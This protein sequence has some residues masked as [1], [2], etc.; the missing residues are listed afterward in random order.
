V[1]ESNFTKPY[2]C[3]IIFEHMLSSKITTAVGFFL[4]IALFFPYN[5]AYSANA[6]ELEGKVKEYQSKVNELQG[7]AKSLS[8]QIQVMD[9]QIKLTEYRIASTQTQMEVLSKDI[10]AASNKIN[11][12][13]SSLDKVSEVLFTRI[14]TSYQLGGVQP[15][16]V[17]MAANGADDYFKRI[18][19]IKL[20]RAH[21]Q[22]LLVNTQQ[23]KFDYQNQKNIF[24]EKKQRVEALSK[25]LASY[26]KQLDEQKVEKQN[27]LTT[28]KSSESEYQSRLNDARKELQSIARA[29]KVL[30]STEPR[31][32]SKGEQIGWMGNTGYSFG[33]HLHFGMYNASSLS[34]YSY[35]S[36]WENPL[37][38]LEPKTVNWISGCS[39]DPAGM[40]T[41]GSGSF[42]WP[43]STNGLYVSQA[44]GVTCY[45]DVYYKGNPH[46]ALDMHNNGDS[47]V[48]AIEAGDAYFCRNCTGDGGNGV[49]LFH[50]NGKMSLYWHLQ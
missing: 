8:N 21:D 9:S 36:G 18:N 15:I 19:Y 7:Q 23:A 13:E 11:N 44:A 22:A 34:Q 48:R 37:N 47:A 49:F 12:L 1:I 17:L 6:S 24:E 31:K 45:S 16:H 30:I 41:S 32:V 46:P 39:G 26:T 27:L 25:E 3:G 43:M 29:A 38:Y 5:S 35:Y 2:L 28:T 14:V 33:A 4:L 50:S 20:V 42:S 40:S 10:S